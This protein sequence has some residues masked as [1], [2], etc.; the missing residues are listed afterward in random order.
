M[1]ERSAAQTLHP[2]LTDKSK[3]IEAEKAT[4]ITDTQTA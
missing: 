1:A 4:G 2:T 3:S